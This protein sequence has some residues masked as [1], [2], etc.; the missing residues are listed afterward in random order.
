MGRAASGHGATAA[1]GEVRHDAGALGLSAQCRGE[2]RRGQTVL[3]PAG[4]A[5][6]VS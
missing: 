4:Q 1:G 2:G 5:T 6:V 3:L